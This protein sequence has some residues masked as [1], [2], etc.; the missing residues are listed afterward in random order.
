MES[1]RNGK[2]DGKY[3]L[4][5]TNGQTKDVEY[6]KDGKFH[7]E[8]VSCYKNGQLKEKGNFRNDKREGEYI[9]YDRSG[10]IREKATFRNGKPQGEFQ[11]FYEETDNTGDDGDDDLPSATGLKSLKEKERR[12][13]DLLKDLREFDKEKKETQ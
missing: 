10:R 13:D 8:Y 2:P 11:C 3:T 9:A 7:G 1:Y 12:I 6:F 4:F 5:Y